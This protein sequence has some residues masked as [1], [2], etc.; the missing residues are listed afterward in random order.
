MKS[1]IEL[2]SYFVNLVNLTLIPDGPAMGSPCSSISGT[3]FSDFVRLI[4]LLPVKTTEWPSLLG[5]SVSNEFRHLKH[6]VFSN[7]ISITKHKVL[8]T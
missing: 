2:S 3:E 8:T 5:F 4:M 6:I 7:V 1:I